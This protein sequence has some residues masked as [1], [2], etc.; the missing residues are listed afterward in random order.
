MEQA[1][2]GA[3]RLA[4]GFFARLEPRCSLANAFD[5]G[6][7]NFL[8]LRFVAA[9]LVMFGHSYG[10][11]GKPN[12]GD[13]VSR[14]NW[15]QGVYTGSLA[16]DMFFVISGFL[17]TGSYLNRANLESFLK[18]RALRILPAYVACIVLTAY[19]LGAAFTEVPLADYLQSSDVARYVYRNLQLSPGLAF[20]LPGV[21]AHNFKPNTVNGSIWTLP[22]EVRMYAWVAI[23]GVLGVLR[24]RWL[25]N[26]AFVALV[27]IALFA[28]NE[29]P[30]VPL[31]E[32]LGMAGCFLLGAFCFINR[33][34]IPL[35]TALLAALTALAVATRGTSMSPITL[36]LA[37]TYF[38]IWFA[39][40]PNFH[41]FNR[42]GDYSYG[43]YLWAFPLQ[44]AVST[45]IGVPVRPWVNFV[46]SLPL[47]LVVA[48]ASWHWIEKPAL[49]WKSRAPAKTIP[50]HA[51]TPAEPTQTGA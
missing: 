3:I 21:F 36:G 40:I 28:P 30:L 18:S 33:D 11:S 2:S 24:R 27:I 49:R 39:Y 47:T 1:K 42:F 32:Y 5:H 43:L 16:V 20:N 38:C 25:A 48:M 34:R 45:M 46:I 19:V 23:L 51:T 41:F 44:Q 12:H 31:L 6:E 4:S 7:D 22:A 8:L 50:Q 14:W 10:F 13:F 15:G 35:S 37:L 17:V 29:L 26:A 9:A